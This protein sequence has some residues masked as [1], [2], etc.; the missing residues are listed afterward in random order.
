MKPENQ[1]QLN[2]Y[3]YIINIM[4]N[5]NNKPIHLKAIRRM[6]DNFELNYENFTLAN[7]L[8]KNYFNLQNKIL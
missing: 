2:D 6:I 4:H 5:E 3:F 8:L 7:L 1:K